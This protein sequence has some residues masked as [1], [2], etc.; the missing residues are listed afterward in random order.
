MRGGRTRSKRGI[1]PNLAITPAGI[2]WFSLPIL[3]ILGFRCFAQVAPTVAPGAKPIN[4]EG[5]VS[6]GEPASPSYAAG[7]KVEASGPV[8]VQTETD[9]EGR[10]AFEGV[11]AGTYI[12][13]ASVSGLEGKQT[14]R[15]EAG[16]VVK[17]SL[18]LAPAVVVTSVKVSAPD[19]AAQSPAP[20]QTITEKTL[21]DA[22]NYNERME[23]LLPLVPGVV[24]G[25]DG[26]INMKGPRNTQS[27]ALVNS[28]NVTDPVTGSPAMNL[29]IDVVQSVQVVS[30]PYDPQYGRFTGA[31]SSVE[32]KTGSYEKYHY[33]I[34]NILPRLRDRNGSI[35][36]IEAAT[37]RM[38]L[39]G[40]VLS[41][42]WIGIS[43][44]A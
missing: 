30:N 35:V 36:G 7:A 44:G 4:L 31:V 43:I 41:A 9:S 2:I 21:R 19:S 27:G 6:A 20:T 16:Q 33:S 1:S 42:L 10:Y 13:T 37:P 28:A 38:T 40:P 26:R 23:S 14:V 17:V 5:S 25:P 12:L 22:P 11:P 8:T 3:L 34:Q 39:S 32:T 29:P 18:Q 24:R 15:L